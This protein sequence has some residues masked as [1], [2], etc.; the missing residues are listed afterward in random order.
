MLLLGAP[1]HPAFGTELEFELKGKV[2]QSTGKP[3]KRPWSIVFLTGATTNFTARTLAD[4]NGSFKFKRLAPGL[5]TLVA[6]VPRMGERSM[7]VDVGPSAA[8]SKR[9]ITVEIIFE[10]LPA[11]PRSH[12]VSVAGLS[13]PYDAQREFEKAD[14]RLN[15][16]DPK[17]AVEH[18]KRAVEIA[19]RFA[20]AWN[21]LGTIAY[22]SQQYAQA[23]EHFREAL[24]H[25]PESYPPLVNLGGALLSLGRFHEALET[26]LL[27]VAASPQDALSQSQLGMSYFHLGQPEKAE[28]HLKQAKALDRGHF[29]HPQLTLARIYRLRGRA[30][31]EAAELEEFLQ[32]HPDS[33]LAGQVRQ[34]LAR[35]RAAAP[36]S[37]P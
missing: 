15:K 23:E 3:F 28:M 13:V 11:P 5:Y 19:P 35:A 21:L 25:E 18:L 8:G 12:G 14:K 1:L 32:L 36:H 17:G 31:R 34:E 7:T 20:A 30:K 16:R 2:L 6:A 4:A 10:D 22:K 37:I 29:S 9:S 24:K 27:A 26:N 33:P